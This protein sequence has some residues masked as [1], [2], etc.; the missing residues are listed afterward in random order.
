LEGEPKPE[1]EMRA[2][3]HKWMT[4]RN[5]IKGWK[6]EI[7]FQADFIDVFC[8]ATGY[9]L[10]TK[11][12]AE[13]FIQVATSSVLLC[14]VFK[15]NNCSSCSSTLQNIMQSNGLKYNFNVNMLCRTSE[16]CQ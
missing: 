2:D 11:L 14:T 1:A 13:A 5:R 8:A 6:D 7:E 12:G 4:K 10:N 9:P 3:A 15:P 16:Q